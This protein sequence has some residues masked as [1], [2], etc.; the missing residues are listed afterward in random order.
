LYSATEGEQVSKRRAAEYGKGRLPQWRELIEWA[1]C[2]WYDRTS[3]TA[4]D[5]H[6]EVT[7]FVREAVDVIA[8]RAS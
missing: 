1:V 4:V 6:R 7:R 3:A 5:R 2:L 8:A